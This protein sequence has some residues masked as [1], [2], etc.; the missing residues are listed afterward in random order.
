MD[1]Q[2]SRL[3]YLLEQYANNSCSRAELAELML[4]IKDGDSNL[5]DTE[6][7]G[8]WKSLKADE[9]VPAL[10]KE[11][12]YHRIIPAKNIVAK[13]RK[14][15]PRIAVA[16]SL[17]GVLL[18]GY[19]LY[20]TLGKGKQSP[21]V[22]A[23]NDVKPG[24]DKAILTLANGERVELDSTKG[25]IKQQGGV[26]II[27]LGGKL[28]YE[29]HP[30]TAQEAVAY[31]TISTPKGG[32]YQ[33]VLADGTTV[34]LNAASS[35]KYPTS[36]VGDTR[37]VELTGEGYF[38]VAKNANKPFH[39]KVSGQD[40]EVL[41]T[42]FNINAYDDE[43]TIRTTLLEGSVK[44]TKGI[45][46]KMLEPGQQAQLTKDGNLQLIKEADTEEA[47]AWVNGNF[48][49]NGSDVAAFMRQ[50]SRWYD[51]DVLYEGKVP[52]GHFKGKTSRTMSLTQM[53]KILEYMGINYKI[54]GKKIIIKAD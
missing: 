1:N 49:L 51:V 10:D 18:M 33:L 42:H 23:Q 38:E 45:A 8:I 5:L 53:F 9:A 2:P 11:A 25:T 14:L 36:F 6:L 31:N 43:A 47:M 7:D 20:Q 19:L 28:S 34:W 35:L 24:G 13:Q 37:M 17:I 26:T 30:N 52:E 50:V 39:V 41:G 29:E 3:Q 15:W 46:T 48:I 44:V 22:L 54:E 4:L 21:V 40:V 16:A 12:I 32:Q 27:N